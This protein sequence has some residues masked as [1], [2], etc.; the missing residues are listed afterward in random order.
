MFY[1]NYSRFDHV[2]EQL[3]IVH[4]ELAHPKLGEMLFGDRFL[5]VFGLTS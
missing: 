3:L 1:F 5:A 4:S 2:R